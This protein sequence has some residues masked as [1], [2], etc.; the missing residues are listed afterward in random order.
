MSE[1]KC[2]KIFVLINFMKKNAQNFFSSKVLRPKSFI[3]LF[4]TTV[5]FTCI[6]PY[7]PQLKDYDS[8][9]VVEGLLTNENTSYK[10]K[11]SM[12]FTG[13]SKSSIKVSD[14][15]IY[16]YDETGKGIRLNNNGNGIYSTDSTRFIGQ[17]GKTYIL[18]I[19]RYNGKEYKEYKSDSCKMY[20]V[21]KI[22]SIYF[23]KNIGFT[24]NQ[25][26]VHQ[27]ISI[28][29]DSKPN[30][31]SNGYFRWVDEEVWK[32]SLPNPKMFD[33]ITQS[34]IVPF[35]DRRQYCWRKE[36]SSE[37]LINC[38]LPGQNNHI[39]KQPVC[40]IGSDASDRLSIQY[41][42]LVKQFSLSRK[43]YDFWRNLKLVS[44]SEGDIFMS[45]PFPVVS[46]IHNVND[47][48]EKILGYFEV[49]AVAQK[50]KFITFKESVID[51][52]LPLYNYLQNCKRYEVSP[53]NY[54]S[55][56]GTVPTFDELYHMWTD[57]GIYNFIEPI[58]D[59]PGKLNKLV[60]AAIP[61]SVCDKSITI[62]KPDYWIDL[63]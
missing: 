55:G 12:T 5:L 46:N 3:I 9:L 25:S 17:V 14:A 24:N 27:G 57:K 18:K 61:C 1:S 7:T 42:I 44:E 40:F 22:D 31:E 39:E 60:F 41:S 26:E 15:T 54:A 51:L 33:Y 8:W 32:I 59:P 30:V 62:N 63:Y 36:N 28:Y 2:I 16:I 23:E 52:S 11:L 21:S 4:A 45:Q 10:I 48:E 20:P 50:R 35:K 43:E 47:P 53:K 19:I 56:Y 58:Y 49:S 6:D 37:V 29:L 13:L 38:Y 34:V